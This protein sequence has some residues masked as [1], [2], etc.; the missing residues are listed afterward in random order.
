MD[1]LE[2]IEKNGESVTDVH[3]V[4]DHQSGREGL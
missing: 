3:F 1:Y 4:K 2:L